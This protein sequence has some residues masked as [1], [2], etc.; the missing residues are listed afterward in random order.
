MGAVKLSRAA[1]AVRS[2][3]IDDMYGRLARRPDVISFAVGAPDTTLLPGALVETLVHE[4]VTKYGPSILQY[5][6]TQGFGP[7]LEQ[8]RT[9]LLKRGID[10]PA[11]GPHIATGGSGALHSISTALL[12]PGDVVLVERPSYGPAI[13][14][15]RSH[16]GTVA[17]VACD[18]LGMLP[19][20]LD[21]ALARTEPAFVYLLPTFQNPTG[22]T[23]TAERRA[24]VAE[25]IVRHGALAVEDDVYTD[26]RYR[27]DPLP[28]FWSF[29]PR[30][31]VYLTSLSKT[32]VPAMRIG[33]AVMPMDLLDSV[34]ALKQGIDMQTSSFTQAIAAE[35]LAGPYAAAQLARL[36]DAY[37]TKLD[38]L[39]DALDAYFPAEFRW[40]RPDGGLFVWV[41]GPPG[42]D[43]DAL[44][45][46]A[47]ERGVAY[48]PGSAFYADGGGGHHNTMRLSFAGAPVDGIDRGIKLLAT[49]FENT[50]NSSR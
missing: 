4:V 22:Q 26:L 25:V 39:A 27:G 43:A 12:D 44:L 18:D 1:T 28:A 19:D 41:E 36:V 2:G 37:A 45:D 17:D 9:L 34:L 6:M 33:I 40:R 14:M 31:T 20:A 5:G 15:F 47:L 29:A 42:F 16:Q 50:G 35:F 11:R 13:K 48:L 38:V 46:R 30:N 3:A 49:L 24:Q 8:A 32:L 21:Q 10:C 23:M 7:L